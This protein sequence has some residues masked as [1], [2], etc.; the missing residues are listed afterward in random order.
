[1][2]TSFAPYTCVFTIF[3]GSRSEG[4]NIQAWNPL[5]AAWA[6]TAFAKFPVEEHDTTS[7]PK[8]RACA[9]A[10]ET[11]RSLKLREGMQTA[12]FFRYK[13]FEPIAAPSCGAFNNGVKPVGRAGLYPSGN[14]NRAE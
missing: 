7:N 9:S 2:R 3:A 6:A 13:L 12:S 14:G 10:T 11:T 8:A 5:R 1:M 4:M